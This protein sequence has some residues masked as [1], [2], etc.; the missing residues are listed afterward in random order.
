MRTVS[1][2]RSLQCASLCKSIDHTLSS[3]LLESLYL[4]GLK[5]RVILYSLLI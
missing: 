5:D 2:D 3:K 1:Q 4:C